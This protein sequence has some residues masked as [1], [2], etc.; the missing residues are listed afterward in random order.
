MKLLKILRYLAL[1]LPYP[2]LCD[3]WYIWG[4]D[5]NDTIFFI[6]IFSLSL[7]FFFCAGEIVHHSQ[8]DLIWPLGLNFGLSILYALL[9][10]SL[11]VL[12]YQS[13][14]ASLVA[15]P[16]IITSF[17]VCFSLNLARQMQKK[18]TT[19]QGA[20]AL[21][22]LNALPYPL[23]IYLLLSSLER[24]VPGLV[25][26]GL[27]VIILVLLVLGAYGLYKVGSRLDFFMSSLV[28]VLLM[29]FI[30]FIFDFSR[31][32]F[33][34]ITGDIKP[35]FLRESLF[36]LTSFTLWVQCFF[37]SLGAPDKK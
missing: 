33:H 30:I 1:A 7:L 14:G 20:R 26:L 3:L 31:V 35:F 10:E 23:M 19:S 16:L 25:L 37:T 28:S 34:D 11:P 4:Y 21:L 32:T 2:A 15:I 9:G 22:W 27:L 36:V 12:G 6:G 8:K 17:L 24:A 5:F 18:P 29:L 13:F